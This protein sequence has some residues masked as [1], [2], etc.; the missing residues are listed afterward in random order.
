MNEQLLFGFKWALQTIHRTAQ[1]LLIA[2]FGCS[3]CL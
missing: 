2:L 1:Q 3:V